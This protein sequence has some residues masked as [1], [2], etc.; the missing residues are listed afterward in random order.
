MSIL[1][2]N[3]SALAILAKEGSL[4]IGKENLLSSN[5][6]PIEPSIDNSSQVHLT[7][8]NTFYDL[9]IPNS[10]QEKSNT[11]PGSPLKRNSTNI[12]SNENSPKKKSK[13]DTTTVEQQNI[14][15]PENM[16]EEEIDIITPVTPSISISSTSIATSTIN[17]ATP[18]QNTVIAN[19]LQIEVSN[20]RS[21]QVQMQREINDLRIIFVKEINNIKM[22]Y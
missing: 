13:R 8:T 2:R 6:L 1:S 17:T 19:S 20:L 21:R 14:P 15:P 3:N 12:I 5:S 16:E 18:S 4:A 22:N 10:A 9:T 7:R 11:S